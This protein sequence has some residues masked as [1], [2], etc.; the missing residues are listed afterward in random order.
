MAVADMAAAD[1]VPWPRM[2]AVWARA[3][4]VA[5]SALAD[6]AAADS[7]SAGTVGRVRSPSTAA[8]FATRAS[9][10][11][12]AASPSTAAPSTAGYCLGAWPRRRTRGW[13]VVADLGN[14]EV[15][16]RSPQR[17]NLGDPRK[18]SDDRFDGF[19]LRVA[20]AARLPRGPSCQMNLAIGE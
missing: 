4:W 11:V 17:R 19:D 18:R 15:A 13:W 7:P 14:G 3:P 1:T 5:G 12:F 6:S 9:T 16:R 10:A 2:V 20:K 8:S